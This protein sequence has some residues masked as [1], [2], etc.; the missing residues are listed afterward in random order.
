MIEKIG[1][2]LRETTFE[3]GLIVKRGEDVY[4]HIG[5][6]QQEFNKRVEQVRGCYDG[7]T[8]HDNLCTGDYSNGMS[9]LLLELIPTRIHGCNIGK[10]EVTEL[11][12]SKMSGYSLLTPKHIV[13]D[14]GKDENY[15]HCDEMVLIGVFHEYAAGKDEN[16]KIQLNTVYYVYLK[17]IFKKGNYILYRTH[18]ENIECID[19]RI[20]DKLYEY[21]S[22]E[23]NIF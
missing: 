23:Y 13:L 1:Y 20:L 2:I 16:G 9:E 17:L 5:D 4:M 6:A 7:V 15:E 19:E 10:D 22:N 3:D 11:I 8:I 12:I 18:K 21:V 14:F